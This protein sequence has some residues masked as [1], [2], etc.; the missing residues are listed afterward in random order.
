MKSLDSYLES[1]EK[2]G[3]ELDTWFMWMVLK[4]FDM[5][6]LFFFFDMF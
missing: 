3:W 4:Y 6:Y 1:R 2:G 5:F